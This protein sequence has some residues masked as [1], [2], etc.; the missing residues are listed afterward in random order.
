MNARGWV[1]LLVRGLGL[2]SVIYGAAGLLEGFFTRPSRAGVIFA[3]GSPPPILTR[4]DLVALSDEMVWLLAGLYLLIGGKLLI[5]RFC[6]E[7][8]GRC[9]KCRYDLKGIAPGAPCPECG[10]V[11]E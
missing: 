9:P 4:R 6:A 11:R 10:T 7:V 8:S 2:W 3:G 1:T 5:N